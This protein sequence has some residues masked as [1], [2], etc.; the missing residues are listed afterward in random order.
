VLPVGSR[1]KLHVARPYTP[2]ELFF[3]VAVEISNISRQL[4]ENDIEL[5]MI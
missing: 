4:L 3:A 2:G 5:K 1:R